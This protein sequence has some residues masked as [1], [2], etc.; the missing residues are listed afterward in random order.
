VL[1]VLLQL[2]GEGAVPFVASFLHQGDEEAQMEAISALAPS[3]FPQALQALLRL[4][5]QVLSL[6]SRRVLVQSLAASPLPE[7]TGFLLS[8]VEGQSLDLALLAIE[9]LA[10]SRFRGEAKDLM[11]AV[12]ERVGEGRLDGAFRR[13]FA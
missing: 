10:Q 12:L 6:E 13:S 3:R 5:P 7:S 11:P 8:V 1:S 2:E 9:S 4:W